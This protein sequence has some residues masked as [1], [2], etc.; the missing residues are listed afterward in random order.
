[1]LSLVASPLTWATISR[2][3]VDDALLAAELSISA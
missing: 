1:M 3:I 2:R